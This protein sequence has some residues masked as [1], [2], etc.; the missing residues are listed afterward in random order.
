MK[1]TSQ[2]V[3]R[4]FWTVIEGVSDRVPGLQAPGK[5]YKTLT[6]Q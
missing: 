3:F 1:T 2:G 5:P 4:Q 6:V